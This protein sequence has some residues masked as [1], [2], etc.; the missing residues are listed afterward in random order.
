MK[1]RSVAIAS[2]LAAAVVFSLPSSRAL[3]QE[4]PAPSPS[5]SASASPSPAPLFVPANQLQPARLPGV[6]AKVFRP[7]RV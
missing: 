1:C 3:A 4:T 6:I 5:A 2:V 7:N